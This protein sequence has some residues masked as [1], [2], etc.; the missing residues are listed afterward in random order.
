MLAVIGDPT[1]DVA[2]N[3]KL[4]E[5]RE[6]IADAT[7]RLKGTVREQPVVAHRDPQTR[8]EIPDEQNRQFPHA[9]HPIPKKH[10]R[11]NQTEERQNRPSKIARPAGDAHGLPAPVILNC[12]PGRHELYATHV[13]PC[14]GSVL[15]H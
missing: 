13:D 6:G 4:T 10:D 8:E 7:E 9:D 5:D 11:N 2:L 1:D 14:C 3:R 15:V 12:S